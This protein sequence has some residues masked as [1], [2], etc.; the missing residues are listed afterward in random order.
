MAYAL[1]ATTTL[2]WLGCVLPSGPLIGPAP[3]DDSATPFFREGLL[4]V[5]AVLLLV[6]LP[7]GSALTR[8]FR[9]GLALLASTDAFIATYAAIAAWLSSP[10]DAATGVFSGLLLVVGVLSGAEAVRTTRATERPTARWS[11]GSRLA[12]CIL[13]LMVP[14]N[15]L[16]Q[17]HVERASYLA[18]FFVVAV[19][20]AGANL[21]RST[22]ML[23]LTSAIIQLA[24]AVHLIVTLRYTL[25]SG[26]PPIEKLSIFGMVTWGL[27]LCVLALAV[28]QVG[29]L[30][31]ERRSGVASDRR[32]PEAPQ[33][34]GAQGA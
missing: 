29:V 15:W 21:A 34:P 20:A 30:A 23:R 4:L 22:L 9:G 8:R 19:S 26:S 13:V 10:R 24:L 18:P 12:I 2:L 14:A 25:F 7:V 11:Q 5:P 28:L 6:L 1:S 32:E 33:V 3:H 27:S 16:M 31:H 17:S